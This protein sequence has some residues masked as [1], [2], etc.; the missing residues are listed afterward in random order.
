MIIS[1][2]SLN[3][4]DNFGQISL[5]EEAVLSSFIVELSPSIFD[6]SQ[7]EGYSDKEKRGGACELLSQAPFSDAYSV[8]L[9]FVKFPTATGGGICE[10]TYMPQA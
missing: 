5:I 1:T 9:A 8:N 2:L 6:N 7:Y 10:L 4:C 3:V